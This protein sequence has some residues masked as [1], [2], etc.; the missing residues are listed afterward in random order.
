MDKKLTG[1]RKRLIVIMSY[2]IAFGYLISFYFT[3]T[4]WETGYGYLC[5]GMGA[6]PVIYQPIFK[7]W[8]NMA[9]ATFGCIGV[10]FLMIAIWP[11]KYVRMIPWATLQLLFVGAVLIVTGYHLGLEK[12]YFLGDVAYCWGPAM[13]VLICYYWPQKD[14]T[15]L[16]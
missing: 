12:V 16:Q 4:S 2:I 1:I 10:L 13:V 8:L 7:Y 9:S 14:E 5:D 15:S 3:F 11:Q 6:K